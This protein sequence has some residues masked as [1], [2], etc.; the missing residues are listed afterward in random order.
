MENAAALASIETQ[1][2]QAAELMFSGSM[3]ESL[4]APNGTTATRRDRGCCSSRSSER[5]PPART[6]SALGLLW[7]LRAGGRDRVS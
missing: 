2:M 1:L 4:Y 5:Q 6:D 7:K 3:P